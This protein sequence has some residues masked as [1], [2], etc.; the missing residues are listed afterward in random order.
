MVCCSLTN[1]QLARW[2]WVKQ[3]RSYLWVSTDFTH[4]LLCTNGYPL[5]ASAITRGL[6]L[7]TYGLLQ[8]QKQPIGDQFVSVFDVSLSSRSISCFNILQLLNDDDHI[9]VM[10]QTLNSGPNFERKQ[11]WRLRQIICISWYFIYQNCVVSLELFT[12]FILPWWECT[13]H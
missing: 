4:G 12:N 9:W 13:F 1:E 10:C 7:V 3:N 5:A 8:L 2:P 11:N 6:L